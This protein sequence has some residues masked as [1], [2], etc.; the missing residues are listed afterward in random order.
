MCKWEKNTKH[1]LDRPGSSRNG[2][3]LRLA[4]KGKVELVTAVTRLHIH[5]K[6][7]VKNWFLN[8]QRNI[9][10]YWLCSPELEPQIVGGFDPSGLLT[11]NVS[12]RHWPKFATGTALAS[13]AASAVT[14]PP[15]GLR[16]ATEDVCVLGPVMV[17]VSKSNLNYSKEKLIV[18]KN[19]YF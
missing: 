11:L 8:P 12:V 14:S 6:H 2:S 18:D 15:L 17:K 5:W 1:Y 9:K 19:R 7:I 16:L 10:M 3:S 4:G 13:A